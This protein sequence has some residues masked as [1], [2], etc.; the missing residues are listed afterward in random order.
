[1]VELQVPLYNFPLLDSGRDQKSSRYGAI[2]SPGFQKEWN[3]AFCTHT[4][5]FE[6]GNSQK[7]ASPFGPP[8]HPRLNLPLT[9]YTFHI[10]NT[11]QEEAPACGLNACK[12]VVV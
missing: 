4:Y 7:A 3:L 8:Q 12:A 9:L 11:K 2:I 6:G 5:L 1:M 10:L